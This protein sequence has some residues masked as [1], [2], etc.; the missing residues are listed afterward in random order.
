MT[1]AVNIQWTAAGA[2]SPTDITGYVDWQKTDCIAQLT[3]ERGT[4]Q[5]YMLKTPASASSIPSVGDDIVMNDPTGAIFGGTVTEVEITVRS[6]A[7]LLLE[8]EITVTDYGWQLDS[9]L[10]KTSYVNMDPADIIAALVSTYGPGGF[11]YTTH[12]QRGGFKVSTISFNYEQLTKCIQ[13]LATQI[14]WDWNV[15]SAKAIHFFFATT[16]DGSSEYNP[17]PF[18]ID[19]TSG[20]IIWPSLDIDIS[21]LNMKNSVFVI[22]GTYA[23]QFVVSPSPGQNPPQYSPVDVYTTVAG[24]LVYPLGYRYDAPDVTL[25]GVTLSVGIDQQ[26]NPSSYQ[27][28]YNSSGPFLLFNAD[29]GGGHVL[30]VQGIAQVPIVAHLD[31]PDSITQ[32]GELQDSIIN[33]QITSVAQAQELAAADLELYGHPVYDVK[34]NTLT[35]GLRVGQIILLDSV[36][37]G[38]TNYPLVIKKIEAVGFS[39]TKL[40][41]QVE[42]IGSDVVSLND[43]LVGLL[44]TQNANNPVD[45]STVLQEILPIDEEI[46]V[47]DSVTITSA[48]SP[49]GYDSARAGFSQFS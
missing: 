32:F 12:V 23:K 40:L 9:K 10:V 25:D 35:P 41:Y 15:D 46:L 31:D 42:A 24:T 29:P 27:V 19:D 47:D 39:P 38:T 37:F 5:F 17:A 36:I 18:N 2:G 28:M 1:A 44:Q 43:V 49:Y 45:N 21:I 20:D 30:M 3:K 14:G 26:E 34:F 11:D 16:E 8:Y 33:S 48:T 6:G 7:G 4:C 13:Q 22:G